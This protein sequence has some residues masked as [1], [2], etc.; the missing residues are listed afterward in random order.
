[1]SSEEQFRLI[2]ETIPTLVWSARTD[3]AAD[4]FNRRWLDY[5]GLSPDQAREWGWTAALHPND[6]I[7]LVSYWKSL[8]NSGEPGEIEARLR[9]HDGEFRWFLF[10]ARPL[11]DESGRVVRWCG[12]N[13]D[14]TNRKH[15][16]DALRT[17]EQ[18]VRLV[19]DNMPGLMST[20]TAQGEIEFVNQQG[21]DYLGKTLEN[22]KGWRAS[23][24]VHPDDLERVMLA[25]RNSLETGDPCDVDHR[26]RGAGGTYR[27]YHAS[28]RPLRDAEN[29][30]ISWYI[31]LTDIEERKQAEEKLRRSEADLHEAQR[32]SLTGSFKLDVLSGK[33]TVSPEIVRRCVVTSEDDTSRLDFWF[34]RI[35][36][37]DRQRVREYFEACLTHK[38]DY[39]ADYRIVLPDGT[40][41]YE[42]AVGHPV[43]NESGDLVEFIGTSIDV[44]ERHR[45]ER[46]LQHERDRLR[47][48]LN[49]NNRVASQLDLPKL[50]QTI[51]TELRRVFKCDLIG[52]VCPDLSGKH[53]RQLM[54][55]YPEGKGFFKEGAVYPIEAS[56]AG[57]AFRNATPFM[58][59]NLIEGKRFWNR[60]KAFSKVVATELVKSGC[61]L[62]LISSGHVLGVLQVMSL[63]EHAFTQYDLEFMGQVAGQI[64]ITFK[65]AMQYEQATETKD[66]LHAE[67]VILREQIDQAFMFEEIVGSSSALRRVFSS[68]VKVAP[69]DSTVLITGETGTGKELIARAIHKRSRRSNRAF[70][71]VN[72]ASIPS[73]LVASEL[74]GHEKGAFTGAFQQRQGRFELAHGGT[75]FLDEVGELPTETQITL[76]RVLQERQFE[77]VGGSRLITTDVRIIAATN[78]DLMA[79][80]AAGTFR[81]DLFYRLNVF[82][83]QVPSLRNRKKD[84]PMLVEYFVQRLSNKMG[85]HIRRIDKKT[86]DLCEQYDWPGNIRELQNV[87]ERSVILSENDTFSIEESYLSPDVQSLLEP[88]G[89]LRKTLLD[90]ERKIIEAALVASKGKIAGH[91]GAAA[92]LG[93]PPS[94]LDSKI[95]QFRIKREKFASSH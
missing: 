60:D 57:V 75:I 23:D 8:L 36:L 51:S 85:K 92:K 79:A 82:P 76:L 7:R 53:L 56:C 19:I 44:T 15:I 31:L 6:L 28:A 3:G 27:W 77:R 90:Q 32:L 70:V 45:L 94:T 87:V 54:V 47:L 43:L 72:C 59:N 48:L 89:P 93:I 81:A 16:E 40:T 35:H 83:L 41:K 91:N 10:R 9:R 49:L 26:L 66:R 5:T 29:R 21:L 74:F 12:T 25:W 58:I 24:A 4:F 2:T 20:L 69:T 95:K 64:A 22:L 55:D 78:R 11:H 33:V 86:L 61:F 52:L 37:E 84:I 42:H 18:K 50:F 65:N 62:P 46:A 30:V 34:N 88:S 13:T 38:S 73:S 17:S 67:N 63:K 80:I 39:E 68:I 1:M 14:I 71:S